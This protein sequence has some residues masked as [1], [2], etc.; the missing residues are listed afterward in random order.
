HAVAV[1][2]LLRD[3]MLVD[4]R[5]ERGPARARVVLRLRA[6]ERTP[7]ADAV[8]GP[9]RLLVPVTAGEGP[10]GRGAARHLV[11]LLRE[12]LAPLRVALLDPVVLGHASAPRRWARLFARFCLVRPARGGR[13]LPRALA[14]GAHPDQ[15]PSSATCSPGPSARR[16]T[17]RG[18]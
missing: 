12:L 4:R 3:G 1:V 10:L 13:A 16:A 8:I 5:V 17:M 9:L 15:C 18:F 7:A 11:L 14:P 6:E 2:D